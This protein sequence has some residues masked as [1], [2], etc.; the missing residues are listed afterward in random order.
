MWIR[1]MQK[2]QRKQ[3]L[4][5]FSDG[6]KNFTNWLMLD[7]GVCMFQFFHASLISYTIRQLNFE[8]LK[9]LKPETL[10]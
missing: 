1:L 2:T 4:G 9:W 10:T 3:K 6:F 8:G 5:G 7:I